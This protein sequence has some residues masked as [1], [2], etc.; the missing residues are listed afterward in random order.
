M[1]RNKRKKRERKKKD[2]VQL[3]GGREGGRERE[4]RSEW[5]EG[6]RTRAHRRWNIEADVWCWMRTRAQWNAQNASS[7]PALQTLVLTETARDRESANEG[8]V[9]VW[10]TQTHRRIYGKNE[11]SRER[12]VRTA[13][14]QEGRTEKNAGDREEETSWTVG[15]SRSYSA[16]LVPRR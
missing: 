15:R 10:V 8:S 9:L 14:G 11:R 4:E 2:E 16:F 13:G 7:A 5:K 3:R 12:R 1:L 6:G